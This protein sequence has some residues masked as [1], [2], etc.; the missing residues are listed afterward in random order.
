MTRFARFGVR[1]KKAHDATKWTD[2]KGDGQQKTGNSE[3]KEVFPSDKQ[4]RQPSDQ[5]NK[6]DPNSSLKKIQSDKKFRPDKNKN[7]KCHMKFDVKKGKKFTFNTGKFASKTRDYSELECYNCK[8]KGHKA[9]DC[10]QPSDG[11]HLEFQCFNCKEQGHKAFQCPKKKDAI[12]HTKFDRKSQKSFA[13]VDKS[14]KNW[15]EIRSEKRRLKRQTD[16][17]QKK[18]RIDI[19]IHMYVYVYNH[20]IKV[21]GS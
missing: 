9:S 21:L 12:M 17:Q 5:V 6:S 19:Y 11:K 3:N 16:V 1:N 20:V 8:Q 13:K 4:E 14:A 7:K 18:V 15:K 10:T 2:L